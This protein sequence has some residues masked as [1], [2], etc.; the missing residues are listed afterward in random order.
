M[1]MSILAYTAQSL[2]TSEDSVNVT[3]GQDQLGAADPCL[4]Y[5]LLSVVVFYCLSKLPAQW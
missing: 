1:A 2:P 5:Y 4:Y 3:V